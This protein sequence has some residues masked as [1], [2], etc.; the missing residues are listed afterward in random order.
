VI[1][2]LRRLPSWLIVAAV[3]TRAAPAALSVLLHGDARA[4]LTPDSLQYL[5]LAASL[6]WSGTFVRDG[7]PDIFRTPLFPLFLVPGTWLGVPVPVAVALQVALSVLV[8]ALVFDTAALLTD[9]RRVAT[10]A[11]I[12]YLLEPGQPIW[13][14]VVLADALLTAVVALLMWIAVR[15]PPPEASLWRGAVLLGVVAAVGAYVKPPGYFLGLLLVIAIGAS[16]WRLAPARRLAS[17][18]AVLLIVNAAVLF[19]WQAR[20]YVTTGYLGFSTQFERAAFMAAPAALEGARTGEGFAVTRGRIRIATGGEQEARRIRELRRTGLPEL[21]SSLPAYTWLH[22]KGSAVLLMEPGFYWWNRILGREVQPAL[23]A[24]TFQ[25]TG[26]RAS[27]ERFGEVPL[28]PIAVRGLLS[29][30]PLCVVGLWAVAAWRHRG[31]PSILV[32]G[33]VVFFWVLISGGPH[34]DIRLRSPIVPLLSVLA[35]AGLHLVTPFVRQR[36][37]RLMAARKPT[38]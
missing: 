3:A 32:L 14:G 5:E 4:L 24:S 9:S 34:A 30:W 37:G 8:T 7:F 12:I 10:A 23:I 27:L 22:L 28:W 6:A 19:V 17:Y 20:N 11:A 16:W 35:A 33:V 21:L 13:A 1:G 25:N 15:H 2:V 38:V 29:L 18:L 26:V 36:Y 31:T